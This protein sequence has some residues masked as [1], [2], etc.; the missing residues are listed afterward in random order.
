MKKFRTIACFLAAALIAASFAGCGADKTATAN[1][2]PS[3]QEEQNNGQR[4]FQGG[5]GV[6]AKVVSLNGDQLTVILA[7]RA[8]NNRD[9]TP[10]AINAGS[11]GGSTPPGTNRGPGGTP[12]DGKEGPDGT[13]T[14]GNGGPGGAAPASGTAIDGTGAPEGNQPRPDQQKWDINNLK[15]TGEEVIYALSGDVTVMK[16]MGDSAKKIDLSE[17]AA[18]D[19]IRFTT[20]TDDNGDET[21]DTIVVMN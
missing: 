1:N 21:I 13:A 3:K 17:L 11:G 4:T 15:F 8:A 7:D 10:P 2:A 20:V 6:M 16:G 5:R 9:G 18:S 19:V 14:D 12:P